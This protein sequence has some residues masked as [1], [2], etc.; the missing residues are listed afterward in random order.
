M[1][2]ITFVAIIFFSGNLLNENL[3]GNWLAVLIWNSRPCELFQNG[4][5][6]MSMSVVHVLMEASKE[7]TEWVSRHQWY[8]D[9]V[10]HI[11]ME[12]SEAE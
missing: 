3:G 10:T 4:L 8:S 1:T 12:V 5:G 11:A 7:D 6:P 2:H 9:P